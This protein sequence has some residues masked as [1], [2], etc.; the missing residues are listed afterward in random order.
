MVDCSKAPAFGA[1]GIALL[2]PTYARPPGSGSPWP[3]PLLSCAACRNSGLVSPSAPRPCPS[4]VSRVPCLL[5][6]PLRSCLLLP[7]GHHHR[8]GPGRAW[9]CDWRS[10]AKLPSLCRR[11]CG[12]LQARPW[13][14]PMKGTFAGCERK[15]SGGT[16]LRLVGCA[17]R[18]LSMP[19]NL[20]GWALYPVEAMSRSCTD[21]EVC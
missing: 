15:A 20:G 19:V 21:W 1:R 8:P 11:R 10:A 14:L 17:G 2:V 16:R 7:K 12:C 6:P 9:L 4:S 3:L 13:L 18:T 5:P